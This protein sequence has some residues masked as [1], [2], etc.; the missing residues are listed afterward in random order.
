MPT[1]DTDEKVTSNLGIELSNALYQDW[2]QPDPIGSRWRAVVV[3]DDD[4]YSN[5]P[6]PATRFEDS[7]DS[8]DSQDFEDFEDFEGS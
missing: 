2:E 3:Q 6:P 7:E 8:Q 1:A 5:H 4:C